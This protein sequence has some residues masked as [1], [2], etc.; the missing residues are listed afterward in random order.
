MIISAVCSFM[1]ALTYTAISK[2]VAPVMRDAW[3]M[4]H[5][6]RCTMVDSYCERKFQAG[7][8]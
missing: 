7:N 3:S 2:K 6:P 8:K 4:F 1:T 5:S